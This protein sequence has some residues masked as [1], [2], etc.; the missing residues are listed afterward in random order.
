MKVLI[1]LSI[2]K[3]VHCGLGQVALNYGY[4]FKDQYVPQ[5]GEEI[6]LLVP[7]KYMGAFSD[8]VHY[9]RARKIY[10]VCPWLTGI[11]FDVWHAIHQLSRYKPFARKYILTIHDFNFVYEK[12]GAKVNNY[13]KKIQCKVDRADQIVAISKFAKEETKRY[14]SMDK[15][16]EVVYNGVERIEQKPQQS[17]KSVVSPYLFSIGE[18][19]DKKN[20]H[21]LI[22]MM[23]YLPEYQLYIAG[24]NTTPYAARIQKEIEQKGVKNVHLLGLVSEEEKSWLYAHSKAFVFPSLF[25]GFGLPVIEAM[26]FKKPV[27]CSNKT[28]LSEIGSDYVTFF[29]DDYPAQEC[30]DQI[31][32]TIQTYQQDA[33]LAERAYEYACEF[34]WQTHMQRYLDL[35]RA[36]APK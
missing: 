3:N 4:Y 36:L 34:N 6:Y 26:L 27:I 7:E 32:Q 5:P 12:E 18:V 2:L 22:D 10:R 24:R 30:A 1:D 17:P 31:R 29:K 33:M 15:E 16:I 25:E 21:V 13:L 8:K 28:S 11:R 23:R 9:I 20:F 19:K 14:M 35:Y